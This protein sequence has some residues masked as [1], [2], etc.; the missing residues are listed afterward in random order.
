MK[1]FSSGESGLYTNVT[2]N[3][4]LPYELILSTGIGHYQFDDGLFDAADS[5][6]DYSVGLSRVFGK[7]TAAVTYTDTSNTGYELF[8]KIA[9]S[10]VALSLKYAF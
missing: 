9:D 2:V 1:R 7:L 10:R 5:Y 8:G 3:W 6:T 4:S